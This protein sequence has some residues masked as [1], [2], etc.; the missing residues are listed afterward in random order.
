MEIVL[1]TNFE[2]RLVEEVAGLPVSTF[3]GG[4]P[5]SLTGGGRPPFVLPS[6]TLERFRSHLEAIHATGRHFYATLNSND[7]GLKEYS[8]DFRNEFIDEVD[9]LL[10]LGVD[11]FVIALPALLEAVREEHP[12]VPVSLSTFARVRSVNQVEYLR[13]LGVGTVIVEEG[14][15]DFRLLRG[16]VRAGFEVEVLVNQTC[17]R[18]C[19]YRGHHLNTSSLCSQPGGERLWFEYPLLECG[20]EVLRDPTRLISSIWVRPE[21]LSVYEEAGVHRF[22]ISGRN[23]STEWL[24]HV[25]RAYASRAWKGNLL[26]LLS[27]VQVKGPRRALDTLAEEGRAPELV[28]PWRA[29]FGRMEHVVLDNQAFPP[30]FMRRVAETDCERVSCASCG[31]CASVAEQVLRIEGE[32]PSRYQPPRELPSSARFMPLFGTDEHRPERSRRAVPALAP[33]PSS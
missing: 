19:P 16:L 9:H 27:L 8:A 17:I 10:A 12:D 28:G 24:A 2:D 5:V 23:R 31:Y 29:A 20:A 26:D 4:F 32:P 18:D 33:P 6:V 25:A 21:D 3:F 1:A 30:G 13:R 14:N 22:K 11:G 15:R 7:L